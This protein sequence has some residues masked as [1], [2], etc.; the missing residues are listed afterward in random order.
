MFAEQHLCCWF[1][2]LSFYRHLLYRLRENA[3]A[4]CTQGR[5]HNTISTENEMEATGVVG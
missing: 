1:L 3:D 5:N 4:L 2:A